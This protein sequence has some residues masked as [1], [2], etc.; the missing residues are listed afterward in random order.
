MR[1]RLD[2]YAVPS[3]IDESPPS[4][5]AD[6]VDPESESSEDEETRR[7]GRE[8]PVA[9]VDTGSEEEP[10][11]PGRLS[12][13]HGAD[14]V[15]LQP[16]NTDGE[17]PELVENAD[18]PSTALTLTAKPRKGSGADRQARYSILS[19]VFYAILMLF[20]IERRQRPSNPCIQGSQVTHM[21][22]LSAN[23]G[24]IGGRQSLLRRRHWR[25]S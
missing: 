18:G 25:R 6:V 22:K 19:L 14:N 7:L 23:G 20:F 9:G 21:R 10:E 4:A 15:Q 24:K 17:A 11:A 13:P 16:V 12:G 5:A 1:S 3:D 2:I 8:S